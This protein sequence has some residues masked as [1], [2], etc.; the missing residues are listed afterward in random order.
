LSKD[1]ARS[2]SKTGFGQSII[3]VSS[4]TMNGIVNLGAALSR[5]LNLGEDG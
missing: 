1:L 4:L 5:T 2:L 3:A